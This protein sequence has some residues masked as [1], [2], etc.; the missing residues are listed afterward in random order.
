MAVSSGLLLFTAWFL[1]ANIRSASQEL[2]FDAPAPPP[3]ARAGTLDLTG[4]PDGPLPPIS[5]PA[6]RTPAP[7]KAPESPPPAEPP[8]APAPPAP[9]APAPEEGATRRIQPS[10]PARLA[11]AGV[12]GVP[13]GF[14]LEMRFDAPVLLH[15]TYKEGP[16]LLELT[17]FP[18]EREGL[19][20][21]LPPVSF[22]ESVTDV[23]R[24]RKAVLRVQ[25]A[26]DYSPQ[27]PL[28]AGEGEVFHLRFQKGR[29]RPGLPPGAQ[30][31]QVARTDLVTGLREVRYR[32][33]PAGHEGSD[34]YVLEVD[35]RSPEIELAVAYGEDRILGKE[36]VSSMAL[37]AG[38]LAAVNASFF[39]KSGDPLGLLAESGKILSM[40]LLSRGVLGVFEG[41]D[42][43]IV[44]NPGFSGRVDF[45]GGSVRVDGVN[46]TRKAGKVI[47]YTPEW[48]ERT[49]TP[50]GGIEIAVRERKVLSM[51][52]GNLEIPPDGF[53]VAV[54]GGEAAQQL[55]SIGSEGEVRVVAG[56]TPPW[57]RADFAVGGGPVLV[58]AGRPRVEWREESF[59]RALVVAQAPRT[60][61][62]TQ[63]GGRMLLVA[64][65]GR[66]P[67]VNRGID[68]YE[69]ADLMVELGC[70]EALNLDGGGST[71]LVRDGRVQNRPSDGSERRVSTAILVLPARKQPAPVYAGLQSELPYGAL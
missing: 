35:P 2:A 49:G 6:V 70:H 39:S 12:R 15:T 3:L 5:A 18:V 34:V 40:P 32:Y 67:G 11:S 53:V 25:V 51:A 71:A 26:T 68:L 46:Q 64:V 65:D 14:D 10:R 1:V 17:L 63:P 23:G 28:P 50:G 8:V 33:K 30:L 4:V 57:D 19:A 22:I 20:E 13:E 59:S 43:V 21:R 62:G 29:R 52:D 60:A 56:M 38:A 44:G 16:R 55:A 69:L 47:L 45:D 9:A 7:A 66:R 61:V 58:R 42:K 27:P 31:N 24:G 48:G 54:Q 36:R 41:G 37:K